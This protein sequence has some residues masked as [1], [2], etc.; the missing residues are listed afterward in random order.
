MKKRFDSLQVLRAFGCIVVFLAHCGIDFHGIFVVNMFFMISGFTLT[1]SG[2]DKAYL[3]DIKGLGSLRYAL[4]RIVKMYPLYII[5]QLPVLVLDLL[6][7]MRAYS[8]DA[9]G[10]FA[11]KIIASIFLV[12]AWSPNSEISLAFNG[13][14][15]YLSVTL[16]L[17][18]SFPFLLRQIKKF[19][20][21]SSLIIFAVILYAFQLGL[22]FLA[23]PLRAFLVAHAIIPDFWKFEYWFCY[24]FPLARMVDFGIGC[25][26]AAIYIKSKDEVTVRKSVCFE[27]T[28]IAFL[29]IGL[30]IYWMTDS[31]LTSEAFCYNQIF[32]P[33]AAFWVYAFVL[34]KGPLVKLLT[35]RFTLF[36]GNI[37]SDFFL[38]HQN[39]IRFT[40][41]FL[42]YFLAM[43][44][45][46]YITPVLCFAMTVAACL[47]WKWLENTVKARR[48]A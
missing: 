26:L 28:G 21:V 39:I 20:T 9:A 25:C 38:I 7:L 14:A 22:G 37:S 8:P 35:N 4:K 23:A 33:A 16:F 30:Y 27:L 44:T 46:K 36:I 13:V 40:T 48:K 15:W 5:C 6:T 42:S 18:F 47:I 1:Y 29:A 41:I 34:G 11:E 3:A 32:I 12:Q 19:R 24:I 45:I 17:Y 43:S 10:Y 31:I 2:Y